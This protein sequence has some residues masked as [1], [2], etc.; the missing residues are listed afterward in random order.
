MAYSAFPTSRGFHN[1][2]ARYGG[3]GGPFSYE[4]EAMA[5]ADEPRTALRRKAG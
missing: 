4:C 1:E 5:E 3:R 2:K